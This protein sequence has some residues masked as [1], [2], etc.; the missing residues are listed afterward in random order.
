VSREIIGRGATLSQA[1]T[2]AVTALLSLAAD[3]THVQPTE[4]REVRA[5]GGSPEALLAHWIGECSYVLDVEGFLCRSIDLAVF[6]VLPK[7]G[8]EPLRLHAFLHGEP[9][10]PSRHD[11]PAAIGPIMAED[12][13]IAHIDGGYEIRLTVQR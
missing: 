10:D 13:A 6:D 3:P 11:P 5:H 12:I 1:F 2:E 8:A 9:I 4:V 7:P